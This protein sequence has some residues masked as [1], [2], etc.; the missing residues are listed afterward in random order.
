MT[1]QSNFEEF[2]ITCHNGD[3]HPE[4]LYNLISF[5]TITQGLHYELQLRIFQHAFWRFYL[6]DLLP[7]LQ[8]EDMIPI[9]ACFYSELLVSEGKIYFGG[10]NEYSVI[11]IDSDEY[12]NLL[13]PRL[14][15]GSITITVLKVF[16][17]N[18][19]DDEEA[20]FL[21][22]KSPSIWSSTE[23]PLAKMHELRPDCL[24]KVTDLSID[25]ELNVD[26]NTIRGILPSLKE[27]TLPLLDHDK[28][29]SIWRTLEE[30]DHKIK[31]HLPVS[32]Y[33]GPDKSGDVI[34][35][36]WMNLVSKCL[37]DH[38]CIE[39]SFIL[40][41]L[42]DEQ[43]SDL[44]ELN[45]FVTK[46]CDPTR[47][48]DLCLILLSY[49]KP[50]GTLTFIPKMINLSTV[51]ISGGLEIN[52]IT[53]GDLSKLKRLKDLMFDSCMIS[54][55]WLNNC[56]PKYCEDL[57]IRYTTFVWD[58]PIFHVPP[59]LRSITVLQGP[60]TV[61]D[62][63][64]FDFTD[65]YTTVLKFRLEQETIIQNHANGKDTIYKIRLK[66]L[67][68]TLL[69]INFYR[70][71]E[72]IVEKDVKFSKPCDTLAIQIFV[73]EF[74]HR[75]LIL[76]KIKSNFPIDVIFPD[77]SDTG[78]ALVHIPKTESIGGLPRRLM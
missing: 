50:L 67:P 6:V 76:E 2:M 74:P 56:I 45:N 31:V 48:N 77:E 37:P 29:L 33:N 59:S 65:S 41:S 36:D 23:V 26:L 58:V 44:D 34:C 12:R 18:G 71:T 61:I 8:Y 53:L 57:S 9:L 46:T 62:L 66:S 55:S 52:E 1:L 24:C 4:D 63:Y 32:Y 21:L 72:L 64:K 39:K 60:T 25:N 69:E 43:N 16:D 47:F 14:Q 49:V 51:V 73:E 11:K 75:H 40:F 38:V 28:T 42:L 68:K 15:D 22:G 19:V 78:M 30:V 35:D 17:V 54:V 70:L 7:F 27:L 13:K 3:I 10:F 5:L 20:R